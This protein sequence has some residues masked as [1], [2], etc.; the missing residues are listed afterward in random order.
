[1]FFKKIVSLSG[2]RMVYAIFG[3]A[4]SI[5]QVRIFGTSREVEVFFVANTVTYM[6]ISLTQSGQLT[7]FFLPIYLSIKVKHGKA[8]AHRAFSVLVNRFAIFL[9]IILIAFYFLS[10]LIV[11]LMAPGFTEVDKELCV[12]MFRFFLIFLEI[13]FLNSFIDVTLN[14]EKIFGRVELAAILNGVISLILLVLFYKVLGIWILVLTLFVGKVVEFIITLIFVKKVGIKYSFIWTESTFDAKSFFKLMFT[15]S[16][17]VLTTQVYSIVFTAMATLLPQGTYAMFKYVQQISGKASGILLAPLS[18]VFF[19]HFSNSVAAGEKQLEKKMRDPILYSAI[20]GFIFTCLV[21]L[22]GR[23]IIDVLWKS[24]VMSDYFL[25]IGY[26]MLIIN[27]MG[28]TNSAVGSIYRR[29]TI[30]M[31]RGKNLYHFWIM[32]QIVSIILSYFIITP[33]GWFGLSL[34]AFL[35]TSLM[36]IGSIWVS[37][38]CGIIFTKTIDF[39]NFSSI[40][41]STIL[42]IIF[43][44]ALNYLLKPGISVSLTIILKLVFAILLSFGLLFF[45]HKELYKKLQYFVR[46]M[47]FKLNKNAI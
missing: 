6:V 21:I 15:T 41:L 45:R 2:L 27:F 32:V 36:A 1:M 5:L 28:F 34:V 19:S 12:K 24:K 30:S 7:E 14:A 10:P 39:R 4:Y 16:G 44:F 40:G 37:K 17:Y 8:A 33:F 20:L 31:D 26:W 22:L 38:K 13:L 29:V 11:S 35:N 23:E 46:S 43:S 47:V 25:G 42:F 18:T 9:S 3:L